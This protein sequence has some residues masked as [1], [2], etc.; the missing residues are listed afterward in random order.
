MAQRKRWIKQLR[1]FNLAFSFGI[2]MILVLLLGVYGGHWLDQRFGTSPVF[3]LLGIF[4]GV[5]AGFYNL[6]SELSKLN[7]INKE[8]KLEEKKQNEGISENSQYGEGNKEKW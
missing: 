2:S 7:E 6:W 1:H 4:L 5:G 8:A 3:L